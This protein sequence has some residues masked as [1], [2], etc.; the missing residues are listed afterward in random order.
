MAP[1][2]SRFDEYKHIVRL[3]QMSLK[4][5]NFRKIEKNAFIYRHLIYRHY[6][7]LKDNAYVSHRH[8]FG[9]PHG[10]AT[11]KV[12]VGRSQGKQH[13]GSSEGVASDIE[14][15]HGSTQQTIMIDDRVCSV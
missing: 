11:D 14:S 12:K 10:R 7:C 4:V 1:K 6:W 15:K 8:N 2:L 13:H 5:R 3:P 9:K